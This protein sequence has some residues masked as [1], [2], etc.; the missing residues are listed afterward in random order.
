MARDIEERL[1]SLNARRKGT[2]R[3]DRVAEGARMDV[4]AK[5]LINE[6]WER[7]S[8][9]QP[10]TRY[11]LGAMEAVGAQYTRISVE[12]AERVGRQLKDRLPMHVSFE[13]QGSV[14]LDVHIRGVSDV[15]LLTLDERFLT[16]DRFGSQAGTYYPSSLTSVSALVELR[17]EAEKALRAAYPAATVDC[18]GG[19]CIAISGG[20]LARPVDVVPS[21]WNDNANYQSTMQKRDRGVIILDRKKMATLAQLPFLHIDRVSTR[22]AQA[23]GGLRKAIRLV[24]NVKNDAVNQDGASKLPSFDIAA[25]LYHADVGTLALGRTHELA[26]LY[27]AQRFIDWCWSN[28][29]ISRQLRTPD[30]LRP[31]LNTEAKFEGLL[32]V[33]C[34]LDALVKEVV[35][36]QSP[37][38]RGLDPTGTQIRDVLRSSV[39]PAAA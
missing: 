14:P 18:S 24:K 39:V 35:R 37:S 30:G 4:I 36:E 34:E 13:L 33:S 6:G 27:E 20:S 17:S 25:L 26:V 38:L 16:Y 5:S 3:L 22:D 7:R 2:D 29:E 15:D 9:Y 28:K 12:T 1:R 32:T 8:V 19:K 10:Y 23:A 31:V 21:H 11:S